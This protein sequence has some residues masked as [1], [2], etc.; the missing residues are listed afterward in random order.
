MLVIYS[1]QICEDRRQAMYFSLILLSYITSK[2]YIIRSHDSHISSWVTEL[3]T[4]Q[5]YPPQRVFPFWAANAA[6]CCDGKRRSSEVPGSGFKNPFTPSRILRKRLFS[7]SQLRITRGLQIKILS[8]NLHWIQILYEFQQITS[9][10]YVSVSSFVKEY[11]NG[12]SLQHCW[13]D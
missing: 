13:E 6:T 7:K 3:P 8:I 5:K 10:L 9:P 4:T 1:S 12:I 2:F 11:H